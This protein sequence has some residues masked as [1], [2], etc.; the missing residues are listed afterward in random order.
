MTAASEATHEIPKSEWRETLDQMTTTHQGEYVTLE[1]LSQ[2]FGD[3]YEAELM[4][5]A[6]LE[7]DP[8]DD[9]VNV[10]VGGRDGRYPVVLRHAVE[11]PKKLLVDTLGPEIPLVVQI[12]GGDD[13][14]T[15]VTLQTHS[16][17]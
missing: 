5:F 17:A 4:P 14:Q 2:D 3:E 16:S 15:L 12:V 10:G 1:L 11:H 7:Y 13:S 8:K 9:E 6:Y